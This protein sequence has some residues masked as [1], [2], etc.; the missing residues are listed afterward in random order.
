MAKADR[1]EA[2]PK[3]AESLSA[4][5]TRVGRAEFAGRSGGVLAAIGT[6][7]P[8]DQPVVALATLGPVLEPLPCQLSTPELVELLK[9]PTCFGPAR[10]VILDQLQNRYR[11]PFADHWAFVRFAREQNLGLDFT[12]PPQRLV[13]PV[14]GGTK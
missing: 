3:L 9:Q 11:R 6:L 5:L 8:A 2:L 14:D 10:R 1:P 12:S 7:A 13:A 4:V